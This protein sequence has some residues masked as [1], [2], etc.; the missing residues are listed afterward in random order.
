[1]KASLACHSYE[2]PDTLKDRACAVLICLLVDSVGSAAV[3]LI[4]QLSSGRS[5]YF[6]NGIGSERCAQHKSAHT[7]L[8]AFHMNYPLKECECNV[9]LQQVFLA[10]RHF[11]RVL[12]GSGDDGNM[13]G[14]SAA[15]WLAPAYTPEH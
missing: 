13:A 15:V 11:A 10:R 2:A 14:S 3:S 4:D 7:R 8:L 6:G 12:L 9:L 1:M 5:Q